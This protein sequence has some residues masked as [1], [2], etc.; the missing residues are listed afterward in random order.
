MA[1]NN[2]CKLCDSLIISTAVAFDPTTNS[3][4]ITIP[5]NG[6]RNCDKVCIVVAQTIPASTT[7]NAL[8]NI[9]INGIRF[10]LQRCNCTQA[11]ACE[12]RTRTKYST[13]VVTNSVS[14]AFRLLGR[15]YPCYPE[16]LQSLPT[17]LVTAATFATTR[18]TRTTS[19]K[20]EVVTNE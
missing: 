14:G 2:V 20:K 1:C 15:T 6:Y 19:N 9:V 8:V 16:T 7:I 18:T 11:T 5:D 3:L 12:I 4:D 10:P 13:K 17:D